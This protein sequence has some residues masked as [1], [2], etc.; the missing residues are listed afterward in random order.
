MDIIIEIKDGRLQA[1]ERMTCHDLCVFP[2]P[3][4]LFCPPELSLIEDGKMGLFE[5]LFRREA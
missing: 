2:F 4:K 3:G 5:S 1:Q